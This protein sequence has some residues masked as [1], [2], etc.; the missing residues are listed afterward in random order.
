MTPY[1]QKTVNHIICLSENP[2]FGKEYA[3]QAVKTYALL[4]PYQLS[5][6]TQLIK[7][8]LKQRHEQGLKNEH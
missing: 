3:N 7:Q 5:N 2:L 4:D 1:Q 8:E 6:L